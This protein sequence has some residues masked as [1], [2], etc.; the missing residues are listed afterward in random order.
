MTEWTIRGRDRALGA[1]GVTESFVETLYLPP[2]TPLSEVMTRGI[3]ARSRQGRQDV[4]ITHVDRVV[5]EM[6][7]DTL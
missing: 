1:L 7:P 2:A 3:E 5:V 6:Q 4:L